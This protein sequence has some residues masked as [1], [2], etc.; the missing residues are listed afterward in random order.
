MVRPTTRKTHH[1]HSRTG[2]AQTAGWIGPTAG[3][4][5]LL[6][7]LGAAACDSSG[8][9]PPVGP[10][11]D[12]GPADTQGMA[13]AQ[14]MA[15]VQT[16]PVVDAPPGGSCVIEQL[17]PPDQGAAHVPVKAATG[18]CTP[19]T[20]ATKPPASGTH[21]G[22]WAVFRVYDTPVPWGFLVHAMEH[23]AVVIAYN[24]SNCD[25]DIAAI[26]KL[27][28]DTPPKAA[29]PRPPLIVTPDPTL[30]V[31]FAAASW[32][33]ILRARCFDRAEFQ[34]FITAHANQGPEFFATDCGATDAEA[35]G[36]CN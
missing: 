27:W 36:W 19:V 13:D 25:A 23:G 8:D 4:L 26:E 14:G 29:C 6:A 18:G 3:A 32:G 31:P 1:Y 22:T 24:C 28:A 21:Y 17:A 10:G 2:P 16:P 35:N 12:G 33:H 30:D 9:G 11:L 5:M 20:Y 34:A 15:D 7:V